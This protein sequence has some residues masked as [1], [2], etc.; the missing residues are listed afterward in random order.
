MVEAKIQTEMPV[1]K[2]KIYTAPSIK[3]RLYLSS[4]VIKGVVKTTAPFIIAQI[5]KAIDHEPEPYYEVANKY[6]TTIIIGD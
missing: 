4:P 5:K 6:G 2:A 1:L 3:G